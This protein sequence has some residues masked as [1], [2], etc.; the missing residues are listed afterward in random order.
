MWVWVRRYRRLPGPD[1]MA[2]FFCSSCLDWRQSE[3][4]LWVCPCSTSVSKSYWPV[5]T[6]SAPWLVLMMAA[7][8]TTTTIV[9]SAL[10]ISISTPKIDLAPIYDSTLLPTNQKNKADTHTHTHSCGAVFTSLPLPLILVFIGS[11]CAPRSTSLQNNIERA[12]MLCAQHTHKHKLRLSGS[13]LCTTAS[14]RQRSVLQKHF[15]Y[16]EVTAGASFWFMILMR[17]KK[18]IQV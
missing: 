6:T 5:L 11:F 3:L 7:T 17:C 13:L 9:H 18:K 10:Y 4:C 8:I 14:S 12:T 1:L 16:T 2:G 15:N